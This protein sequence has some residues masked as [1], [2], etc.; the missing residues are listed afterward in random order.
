[1]P[2]SKSRTAA[3]VAVSLVLAMG[4]CIL[5]LA[6][7]WSL[8]NPDWMALVLIYW[9]LAVPD[10]V[11]VGTA[12]LTGLFAD[13]LTGRLL[14]QHALAYAVIAYLSLRWYRRLRLFPVP[15]QCL[16]V[17][18]LLLTSQLLVLWTQN[19]HAADRLLGAYWLPSLSGALLWPLVL[20]LLRRLR[21]AYNIA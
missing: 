7:P 13:V 17:L 2:H 18:L 21:R 5:P 19:V 10:R 1:M 16:W 20:M 14:G 15:Q 12:W 11:G 4:L 9:T 6:E 8:L 3:L